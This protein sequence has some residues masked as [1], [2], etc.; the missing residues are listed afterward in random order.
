VIR[1]IAAAFLLAALQPAAYAA[2]GDRPPA[3]LT[4]V[5]T[6]EVPEYDS[7]VSSVTLFEEKIAT[8]NEQG[9]VVTTVRK[10][11]KVL[12]RAGR[13]TASGS[14]IYRTDTGKVRN[15]QGWLI[16][17]SGKSESFGKKETI[18]AAL[19]DNDVYNEARLK[20]ISARSMADPGSVFGYESTVEDRSIFTQ[21]LYRFQ[22]ASPVLTARFTLQLPPG[23]EARSHTFN[24]DAIE[25]QV[26]GSRY[27]WELHNLSAIEREPAQPPISALAPRVAVSYFPPP[28]AAGL[29]PSFADWEAVSSWLSTLN[30]PQSRPDDAVTAKARE[31]AASSPDDWGKIAALGRF[32]QDIKYVSIQ[33]GV[34]RGGGYR[35]HLAADVLAKSYGDCKDKANLMRSMLSAVGIESFPVAIYSGDPRFVRDE[36]PSPQ[37]FNHAVIA[38]RVDESVNVPAV[39]EWEGLGRLLLFDPTDPDTPV[40]YLPDH[41]QGSWALIVRP[42]GGQ[43]VEAPA[44][45][46]EE[47][48]LERSIDV[49]LAADGSIQ[50]QIQEKALGDSASAN[51]AL[52]RRSSEADYRQIIEGWI[53]RGAAAAAVA[54]LETQVDDEE[55]RLS[56]SFSAPGYGQTMGSSLLIFK[57]A[58]VSR[59]NRTYLTEDERTHPVMLGSNAFA[60]TVRVDLPTGFAVDE[61]PDDVKLETDFGS[62]EASW[63]MENDQLVFSRRLETRRSVVEP[64]EYQSVR[65]FYAAILHAE[66]TPVVLARQ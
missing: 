66:Q 38:V 16:Y 56:A 64:A 40:G 23:W 41:E 28:P 24:H 36:W 33:T 14:A 22:G 50:A 37:Q 30:D 61:K 3:W 21:F 48:L 42:E 43:L 2:K 25:P 45:E 12:S 31:L 18:D 5:A 49:T 15:L 8:V 34:G 13:S 51:R 26:S 44:T 17:P 35:P 57:P 11:V 53:T 59:R 10:A 19:A 29:G 27:S 55:F 39:G 4:E 62:Y 60:E 6:R 32:A 47:N 46:P 1:F 20:L 58:V 52:R 9:V 63:A 7:D 65:D 54:D